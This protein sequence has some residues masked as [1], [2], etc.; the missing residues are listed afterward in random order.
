MANFRKLLVWQKAMELVMEIYQVTESFSEKE[1]FGLIS[2]MRRAAVS[3]P[4]NISEGCERGTNKDFASFLVFARSS[5]AELETQ[6]LISHSLKF[7]EKAKA[8]NL[9]EKIIEIKKMLFALRKKILQT[10]N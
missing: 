1:K 4:S 6:V 7:L 8:E 5:A 9:L 3:I 10:A 2:Q